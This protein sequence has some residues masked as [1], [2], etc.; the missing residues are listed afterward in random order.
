ME[1]IISYIDNLFQNY[2][3][4]PQ[5][6][7]AKRELLGIMEDKYRELKE[8]GKSEHEAIGIV[9]SEFGS[10]EEIASELGM[11]Q[12]QE[13]AFCK[14][15]EAEMRLTMPQARE[16]LKVQKEFGFKIAIGVA[17]CILSPVAGVILNAF[18]EAGILSEKISEIGSLIVLLGMV[19]AAVGIF[20]VSG[21]AHGKYEE[22]DSVPIRLDRETRD[23]I[24][25]EYEEQSAPFG[26]KIAAGVILCIASVIPAAIFYEVLEG[27]S[28][29]WM[30]ELAATSLFFFVAAGVFLFITAGMGR[31]AYETLLG[32]G[33]NSRI[34]I[35]KSKKD[36]RI[37]IISSIYWPVVTAIYLCWS[38]ATMNWGFT[39]IV[40]VVAGALFGGISGAVSLMSEE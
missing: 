8:E 27:S 6:Q 23:Q 7:K 17:M 12:R 24:A 39:W 30:A 9:I 22:Y 37:S 21:I 18:Y 11:E 10:M 5:A 19:A 3:D 28:L 25:G 13:Q 15:P 14:E 33:K 16:Y 36:R 20:I 4:T 2:P 29:E 38:I 31:G 26:I 1:T 40:W 32:K 34:K 35:K